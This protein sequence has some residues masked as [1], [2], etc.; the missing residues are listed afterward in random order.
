[1]KKHILYLI[2]ILSFLFACSDDEDAKGG[3]DR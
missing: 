3:M 1:M 2:S